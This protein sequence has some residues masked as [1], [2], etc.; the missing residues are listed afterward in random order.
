MNSVASR[1]QQR[2]STLTSVVL[3]GVIGSVW[4]PA[5]SKER[6]GRRP[7]V[8]P[9]R[10][11]AEGLHFTLAAGSESSK[12]DPRQRKAATTPLSDT[13]LMELL[14]RV[15]AIKSLTTDR[16]S[17]QIR[18]GSLPAPRTAET[19]KLP[20]PNVAGDAPKPL[21]AV[22]E[23]Q[24]TGIAPKGAT[25]MAPHLTVSFNQPMIAMSSLSQ[26]DKMPIPV[27]LTPTPPGKWRWLGTQTLMFVPDKRFPMATRYR[28]TIPAGTKAASGQALAKEESQEFSTPSL[29]MT[30]QLPTYGPQSLDPLILMGFNQD[31]QPEA[32]LKS[33]QIKSAGQSIPYTL[34]T[35]ERLANDPS[36]RAQAEQ[37]G[38]DRCL[39]LQ[40][41][42]KLTPA[43]S[44]QVVLE[45]GSPSKEGPVLTESPQSFSFSTY[46]PLAV[47]GHASDQ[48]PGT[49]LM[50]YFNNQLDGAKS[51]LSEVEV[52]PA[53]AKQKVVVRGQ[54]LYVYGSTKARTS[55]EVQIPASLT[56]GYGQRFGH[57]EKVTCPIGAARQQ[58]TGPSQSF[59]VLDPQGARQLS[60]QVTNVKRLKVKAWKVKPED[61]PKYMT[62]A[63]QRRQNHKDATPPGEEV[64]DEE[65]DTNSPQDE[66]SETNL[67]L[68]KGF[69][70]GLGQLL[71]EVEPLDI[72]AKYRPRY[73]GWIQSTQIGLDAMADSKGAVVWANDL[74]SGKS[75]PGVEIRFTDNTKSGSVTDKDGLARLDY[76]HSSALLVARKGQDTAIL[77]RQFSYY[78]S[79]AWEHLGAGDGQLWHVL[80]DRKLY[81]PSEKVSIKGW[82]RTAVYGPNGDLTLNNTREVS[83]ELKDSRG[84]SILK[85]K[86]P[87]GKLG[88]FNFEMELPK[89][90]NLGQAT[91]YISG[92]GSTAHS[93]QVEEFRRPEFEVT[94]TANPGSSMVGESGLVTTSASYFAGGALANA[95][96]DWNVSASQTSYSPP[97]WAG[98]SFGS[99]TPWW[100]C[101]CW[102]NEGSISSQALP[103]QS[104]ETQTDS[105]G[106]STLQLNFQSTDKPAPQSVTAQATV[107]D[108]NRQA[109]S[110]SA[111]MLV[112]PCQY[113]VGLKSERTFVEKGQPLEISY[114]VCDI[115]GKPVKNRAIEIEA[116]RWDWS[117]GETKK[118]DIVTR[119]V[120]SGDG[121][122]K[123]S[124]PTSEGGTYQIEARVQDDKNR[125][126]QSD[127]TVWVAGGKVPPSR[128]VEQEAITLVPS[129]R[130]Y[131]ADEVAEVLVQVPFSNAE[132]NVTTRRNGI[133]SLEHIKASEGTATLKIPLKELYVP[134][135]TLQVDAV[136][137][138]V[139]TD[140]AGAELP[141]KPLRPAYASG[142]LNLSITKKS[143][144]LTVTVKPAASKLEPGAQTE[145]EVLLKDSAGKPVRAE[146]AL[147][148]VDE[149]VLALSGYNPSDPLDSFCLQRST[150]VIDAHIRQ[151]LLL[152]QPLV[153]A[154]L[155][156]NN[157]LKDNDKFDADGEM[158][159][160]VSALA[161][162]APGGGASMRS[163]R[164][165]GF[166]NKKMAPSKASKERGSTAPTTP[167]KVRTNFSALA[168]FEPSIQTDAEGR[169]KVKVKLPDSLTRYRLIALAAGEK[170]FGK[171]ESS[172]TARQALM[173]R[174]SAPRFLNF[175][176]Q[177]ELP[178]VLQ[179][180]TD[181]PMTVD[182]ACRAT[183]AKIQGKTQGGVQVQVPA[184]DRVEVRLPASA[185]QAGTARFQFAASSAMA[186]DAAEISLPVWTP[187]TTEAFATYG[188]IDQGAVAQPVEAPKDAIK[189]FGNLSLT[190]SST[191]LSELTDAYIYLVSYPFECSE[192]VSSRMLAA[193]AMKDVLEAFKAPGMPSKSEM[194]ASMKRD[195]KRLQG[196]Q[197]YDGGWDYWTRERPS[198]P[199]LTVHVAHALVMVEKK[200]FKVE[201]E[202]LSQSLQ[203]LKDIDS[204]I[205]REYG[206]W[207]RHSIRCYANYVLH[208]AGKKPIDDARKLITQYK[209]E[210]MSAEGIGWLLPTLAADS[211]SKGQVD[212]IIDY[213][214]NHV[215]Q[216]AS[217]ANFYSSYKDKDYL[218]L[219]SDH[220]DDGV[221]LQA[222]VEA[223]PEH[224]L[225]PK[226]VRGLLDH[227]T[228]GH[229]ANT[230]ES[231]WVLIALD[232]YFH[233]FESVT[234][235][236]VARMWLGDK[237]VSQ[238]NFKGRNKD[239]NLLEVPLDQL[240]KSV[241]LQKEGA[242][243]LYYRL[244]MT[245]APSDLKLPAANYGFTVSRNYE[246]LGDNRDVR[247][248]ADGSWHI[249]AGSEVR[250]TLSMQMPSR[251]YHVALVDPLPAGLE[252][253]NPA[254]LG[255]GNQA[256]TSG[257]HKD[258]WWS[259]HWF[260]HQNLR[261]ERVEAFA[262]ELYGGVYTYSYTARA[263]TP[264]NFVV[265]PTKAEEMYHPE[266]FGRSAS[267]KVIV[268]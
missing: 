92:D 134:G 193:A 205:P 144:Q 195:L 89:T 10:G 18:E 186:A 122:T 35:A 162:S 1:T 220:R 212:K 30:T 160:R 11:T 173:V 130:E 224:P 140:A 255:S 234:P 257:A 96:V 246:A 146:V 249:K 99:W 36:I 185:D 128:T 143:R 188:V 103:S 132:L 76:D 116:Y 77:P 15:P 253:L 190:T 166:S 32:L 258:S 191:A 245:Y 90:M 108:V 129:K 208:L 192:Q 21:P 94:A 42:T 112:H 169:A 142:S 172:V 236:F 203:Y 218:M 60:F 189:G 115:D 233:K 178:V 46:S 239:E 105:S 104:F 157:R 145:V 248:E 66:S 19:I 69:E 265:P 164:E 159:D 235:D 231:C 200:G 165:E 177:F 5:C 67:D 217:H 87:V 27:Q 17:F 225:I 199:F 114:V 20:F 198:L 211:A 40:P 34:A 250:V 141:G 182:L 25:E 214:N 29:Q 93:F 194:E 123:M 127:L 131:E 100:N 51:K 13:S 187:A 4:L 201:P 102:W 247:R 153:Q 125:N 161:E 216:T 44:Y 171:G 196:T 139:R 22:T 151:Y 41:T 167:I 242:G 54:Y 120:T 232:R 238:Q 244:G 219:S 262:Q 97:N 91:V 3:I 147:M 88:G 53:L 83:Y 149:S 84:N 74:L 207:C 75:L 148:M 251:R 64:I 256:R 136:G 228:K 260:D 7:A 121:P 47:Q 118:V 264:G 106:K 110:T 107:Q 119:S 158:D 209:L 184:N 38:K 62:Y 237:L 33:I 48:P 254:L 2:L 8:A 113:Y 152:N 263:T 163:R 56:D 50:I 227:R 26:I 78:Y 206:E 241:T 179:N 23:L 229:W 111:T 213:L 68:S 252:P 133:A 181:K 126:N 37:L 240:S 268:E 49:P 61:W 81:K 261:D 204:H 226:L 109:F 117:E 155:E 85:G 230:Q 135:I 52:T 101:R 59:V 58:F 80:D 202:M 71:V 267:D 12:A 266:T 79:Q 86:A 45:K 63:I 243:R 183:N 31:I 223:R 174:P 170:Q 98:F 6:Y 39:V 210:Q 154:E 95:K 24:V 70:S 197:N 180:Q 16:K 43:S 175:G 137:P 55:Y 65:V 221:L 14:K 72:E 222:L 73:I 124:L 82:M 57:T 138:K 28:V 168:L 215:T 156:R 259:Y 176:D 9:S 150:D